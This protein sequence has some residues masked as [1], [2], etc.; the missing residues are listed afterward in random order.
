MHLIGEISRFRTQSLHRRRSNR[1]NRYAS[2]VQ[3]LQE[4]GEGFIQAP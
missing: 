1:N 4:M 3:T 2:L